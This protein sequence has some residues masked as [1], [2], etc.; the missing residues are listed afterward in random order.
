MSKSE[1]AGSPKV[2]QDCIMYST[3]QEEKNTHGHS[4]CV[5]GDDSEYFCCHFHPFWFWCFSP[6]EFQ[7]DGIYTCWDAEDFL[8]TDKT[9]TSMYH[10]WYHMKAKSM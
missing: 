3:W 2:G 6:L 8:L 4:T 9:Y 7:F 10:V 1:V 5:R